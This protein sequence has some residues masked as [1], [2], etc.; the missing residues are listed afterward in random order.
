MEEDRTPW[1]LRIA[2]ILVGILAIALGVYALLY[3]GVTAATLIAFLAF[4]LLVIALIELVRVFSAGISGW[5]RLLNLVLSAL[6]FLIAL[7]I[8]VYP[9]LA[10]GI[11]LGWLVA[12]ALI[13]AGASLAAR[14]TW[15]MVLI[16]AIALVIGVIAFVF[17]PLGIISAIALVAIGLIILG[18]ALVI[19][20]L[21]GRWLI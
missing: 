16:G 15:W 6:A 17:P 10:G 12:I 2:E 9:I 18:F 1:W 3:P 14:G 20:G 8:L 4:G 19:S 11:A 7:A 5:Q 13:F 21:L